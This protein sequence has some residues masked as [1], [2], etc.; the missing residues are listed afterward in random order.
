MALNAPL[1][2]FAAL[3]VVLGLATQ[4]AAQAAPPASRRG[5]VPSLAPLVNRVTP[6]VVNIATRGRVR[7]GGSSEGES[8]RGPSSSQRRVAGIGSGVIVDAKNGYVLTNHHVVR[9]ADQ[10]LVR[11]KDGRVLRARVIGSDAGTDIAVLQIRASG[12][13]ALPLGDSDKLQ[14]G[15]Y[16]LAVGNPF[17]LGQTVTMG[18]VS[19]LGRT[20][21]SPRGYENYIQTD[22]SI[23]PGNSGGPLVDLRGRVVGINA[24]IIGRRTGGTG[25]GFAIPTNMARRVMYQILRYGNIRR[26]RLGVVIQDLTPAVARQI[27]VPI[28]PGA[29]VR[30]VQP[31]TAAARAGIRQWDL[32][33]A[34]DGARVRDA[35]GLRSRIGTMRVG[36]R[37]RLRVVRAK[38]PRTI[39]VVIGPAAR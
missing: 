19:A 3:L 29:V 24:A 8:E 7:G 30:E 4:A 18:I 22:A 34:V 25:I 1:A 35:G 11:L 39:S 14:V 31:N 33:V 32:I 23:N 37:V 12:L 5:G 28:G 38:V 9:R 6:A 27:G 13:A 20:G 15:D 36:D 21:L 2:G 26:G 10:I 16:V 17:G